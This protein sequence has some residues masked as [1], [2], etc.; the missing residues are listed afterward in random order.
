[1]ARAADDATKR[2]GQVA[3]MAQSFLVGV[4]FPYTTLVLTA[5]LCILRP[6]MR[7]AALSRPA[8]PGAALQMRNSNAKRGSDWLAP[9][10]YRFY[11]I[12]CVFEDL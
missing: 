3:R 4:S 11:E 10:W 8:R 9:L 2:E 12:T 1:M 7:G 6:A 5:L